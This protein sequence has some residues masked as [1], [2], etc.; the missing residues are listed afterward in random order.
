MESRLG[1]ASTGGGTSELPLLCWESLLCRQ[2]GP[3]RASRSS[4][5]CLTSRSV[6]SRGTQKPCSAMEC[7][8]PTA[9]AT[10]RRRP[11]TRSGRIHAGGACPAELLVAARAHGAVGG[12]VG[13]PVGQLRIVFELCK[14]TAIWSSADV[15]PPIDGS[16][17]GPVKILDS[18]PA[19]PRRK[20]LP[21]GTACRCTQPENT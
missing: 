14:H 21:A 5:K 17:H 18:L 3:P 11:W 12:F 15:F 19:N 13:R 6:G 16:S 4:R 20:C 2:A 1:H 8:S 10:A 9:T 7:L